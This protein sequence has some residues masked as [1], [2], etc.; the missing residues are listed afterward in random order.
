MVDDLREEIA[1]LEDRVK[2]LEDYIR[3]LEYENHKLKN[4]IGQAIQS[5]ESQN[6]ETRRIVYGENPHASISDVT[7]FNSYIKKDI[8]N[9]DDD[10][11]G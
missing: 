3:K 11:V 2:V 7:T 9:E 1:W 6:S 5:L 8:K 4:T 10:S